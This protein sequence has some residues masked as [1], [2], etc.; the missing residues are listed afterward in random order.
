MKCFDFSHWNFSNMDKGLLFF[1]QT[2][3]EMLFHYGH[4]SLKVPALNLRF[5]CVE[6]VNCI[7]K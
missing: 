6:I 3:E 2:L 4:D 7:K 1:S 5:L